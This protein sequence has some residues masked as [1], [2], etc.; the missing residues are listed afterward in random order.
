MHHPGCWEM[1][2]HFTMQ[3]PKLVISLDQKPLV[4]LITNTSLADLQK[5][6]KQLARFKQRMLSW[7]IQSVIYTPDK[8]NFNTD[9]LSRRP[10][11]AAAALATGSGRRWASP[12]P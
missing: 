10:N 12:A 9:A 1:T 7:D 8:D 6:N 2:E 3:N 4:E 5:K 11:A